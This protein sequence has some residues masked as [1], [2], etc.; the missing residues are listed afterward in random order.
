MDIKKVV[1]DFL[2]DNVIKEVDILADNQQLI[3]S[4]LIDSISIVNVILFFEKQFNIS[5]G[6]EDLAPENFE[7]VNAMVN[8]IE[9]KVG[10][11]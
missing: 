6:E 11:A 1:L 8:I 3:D 2:L 4:G 5:F 7:T 9:K 10:L